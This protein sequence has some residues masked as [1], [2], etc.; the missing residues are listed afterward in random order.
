M[1]GFVQEPIDLPLLPEERESSGGMDGPPHGGNNDDDDM[2]VNNI[3]DMA[4]MALH[5][6]D[7]LFI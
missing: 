2:E 1:K 3:V 6:L 4:Y 5:G 7:D